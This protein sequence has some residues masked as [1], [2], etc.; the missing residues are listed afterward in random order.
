VVACDR[1]RVHGL[2]ATLAALLALP[3]SVAPEPVCGDDPRVTLS[4]AEPLQGS[5][6]LVEVGGTAA[7]DTLAASWAGRA[8]RF[9]REGNPGPLRALVGIDLEHPPGPAPLVL[10]PAGAA[11]CRVTLEVRAGAFPVERLKVPRRYV[12]LSPQNLARARKEARRLRA[13][14]RR[15]SLERLWTGAFTPPL[16]EAPPSDNFGRKRVLNDVPRSPHSGVDFSADPGTPILAPQR[17]RVVLAASLFFSGRTVILD[18][19]LG[20]FSSYAH[21]RE[22]QVKEGELVEPGARLGRVGATGRVTGPHL[23]WAMR[24]NEARVNPMDVLVLFR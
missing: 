1:N 10:T 23:H 15:V 21:L 9:W 3:S 6:V 22:V 13:L 14:Y 4:A 19:G 2:S 16:P 12:E 20:L 7:G 17:G 5:I 8:V 24:L 18:H 11:P